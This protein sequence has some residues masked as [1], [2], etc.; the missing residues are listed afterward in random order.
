M[1]D[2]FKAPSLDA[3]LVPQFARSGE[4]SL[5][6]QFNFAPTIST[7]AQ[8]L[9]TSSFNRQRPIELASLD[10]TPLT[11]ASVSADTAAVDTAARTAYTK[12]ALASRPI[13][14][15]DALKV[16]VQYSDQV[17]DPSR[18]PDVVIDKDGR[19]IQN[20]DLSLGIPQN[21]VVQVDRPDNPDQA[22][23]QKASLNQFLQNDLSAD[24]QKNPSINGMKVTDTDNLVPPELKTALEQPAVQDVPALPQEQAPEQVPNISQQVQD[25]QPGHMSR[26]QSDQY[27]PQ[28]DVPRQRDENNETYAIKDMLASLF[29]N[30]ENPYETI[31]PSHNHGF[32][33]GRYGASYDNTSNYLQEVMTPEIMELLGHPPDW[34]KLGSILAKLKKEHPDQYAKFEKNLAAAE[35]KGSLSHETAGHLR[36]DKDGNFAA[37]DKLGQFVDKL[38]GGKGV[39]TADDIKQNFGKESQELMA[40]K[41][42]QDYAKSGADS[43]KIAVAVGLD[44]KPQDLTPADLASSDAKDFTNRAQKYY[45]VAL[46]REGAGADDD[47]SWKATGNPSSP[48]AYEIAKHALDHAHTTV[49]GGGCAGGVQR[50][51]AD[52]SPALKKWLGS[53][54][55]WNMGMNMLRSHEWAAIDPKQAAPGDIVVKHNGGAGHIEAIAKK[56]SRG[57]L[58]G[59]DFQHWKSDLTYTNGGYYNKTVV[60]RYVGKAGD[61]QNT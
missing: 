11:F 47:I 57:F 39:I 24:L 1:D 12:D 41:M 31:R 32:R 21:L 50:S 29:A 60:M 14:A 27:F 33:F 17:T 59:S 9:F 22:L 38:Q 5:N 4:R 8:D 35:A 2:F 26:Q 18:K 13:D 16:S 48:M 7:Q 30:K 15:G 55:A 3:S 44:K 40:Q 51:L 54:D 19:V 37:A 36:P 56:D 43:A 23:A 28:R 42:V 6:S 52:A 46:K 34:S 61:T 53:G 49:P 25:G 10:V 45:G 58:L 20:T